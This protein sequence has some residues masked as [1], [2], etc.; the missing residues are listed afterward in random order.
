[1]LLVMRGS[2]LDGVIWMAL[3]AAILE[4]VKVVSLTIFIWE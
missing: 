1:M 2:D 4:T 3:Q